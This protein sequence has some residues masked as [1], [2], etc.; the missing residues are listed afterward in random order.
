MDGSGRLI[1]NTW[2]K[3][4]KVFWCMADICRKMRTNIR[5]NHKTDVPFETRWPGEQTGTSDFWIIVMAGCFVTDP[6]VSV[7]LADSCPGRRG[8][9]VSRK[10][11]ILF[12]SI[13]I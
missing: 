3:S 5:P 10:S 1:L 11:D 8:L 4:D 12:L 6:F 2:K 9:I 7:L 13:R